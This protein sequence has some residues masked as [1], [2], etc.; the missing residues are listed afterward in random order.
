[1]RDYLIN[2]NDGTPKGMKKILEER[3]VN[4]ADMKKE[5]MQAVIRSHTDFK[6]EKSRIEH[7]LIKHGHIPIFLPKYHCELNPIERVW[8]QLKRYTKGHCNYSLPS[9]RKNIPLSCESVSL[10]NIQNHF[11]KC[12][13]YMFA[14]LEGLTPGTEL[15]EQVK[16]YKKACLSH[17]RISINEKFYLCTPTFFS[18]LLYTNDKNS[19]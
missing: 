3:G 12:K 15:D 6:Y 19:L 10:E 17:R 8:A 2:F 1:M 13:H 14:Y 16:K 11:R 4:T 18:F 7:L 9:L 5:D